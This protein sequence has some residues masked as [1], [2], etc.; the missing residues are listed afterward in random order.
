MAG[1]RSIGIIIDGNRRWAKVH[2]K[3]TYDGHLAG[4][5]RVKDAI[6]WAKE[7]GSVTDV[8]FYALSTENWK[9]SSLELEHLLLLIE[10]FFRTHAAEL[11]KNNV[12]VRIAGQR[13]RFPTRIQKLFDDIEE[14]TKDNTAITAWFGLSYGGRAEILEGVLALQREKTL[15]TEESLK[16]ALWT[17]DLPDPD[18]I[19]RTGGEQ[20][21]SNF[22]TWGSVYS[23]L[24]FTNTYWPAF[25]KE[26]FNAILDAYETRERRTGK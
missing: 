3:S 1:A 25:T 7:R 19:L 15:P 22:L 11:A 17:R 6:E 24:F 10:L 21:L 18:I 4:L 26:E 20:R 9:R 23:E 12:R 2:G 13:S 5:R 16:S 8:F 14:R